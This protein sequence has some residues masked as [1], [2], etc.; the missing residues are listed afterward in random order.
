LLNKCAQ[1]THVH[2]VILCCHNSQIGMLFI[3]S[4]LMM[5]WCDANGGAY[6]FILMF[7]AHKDFYVENVFFFFL[8]FA[9]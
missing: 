6:E 3:E 8:Y 2:T 5:M 4:K 9:V 7:V 1:T